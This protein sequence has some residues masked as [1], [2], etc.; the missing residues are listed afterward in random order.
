[1]KICVLTGKRGGFGAMRP[2][3]RLM[4]DS[5]YFEL[6]LQACDM[7]TDLRFGQTVDEIGDEFPVHALVIPSDDRPIQLG[8]IASGVASLLR[9]K[10]PDLLLLYGDRGESL[11]AAMVATEMCIPIAHLQGGDTT[12]TMDDRRR[13][14]ISQL[15]DLHFVSTEEASNNVISFNN[16]PSEGVHIVGDSHLDPIY[17]GDFETMEDVR[18]E[19][20]LNDHQP[21]YIVLLHP[22]PTDPRDDN[23]IFANM[24]DAIDDIEKQF[25][26]IY[27]CSDT[28]W[29]K[30][31]KQIRWYRGHPNIQ[32]HKNLPSRTFLGLMNIADM[33][34][35]N[36]SAGIIEAPYMDLA[37]LNIC[38]RQRGRLQSNN[39]INVGHTVSEIESGF[40]LAEHLGRHHTPFKKLYGNGATGKRIIH[41]LKEWYNEQA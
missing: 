13:H 11:A 9:E 30:I 1:M 2:M 27:P 25:V 19:L 38:N 15:A 34:I 10:Q 37:C 20:E 12:G 8:Y 16:A 33:I 14:A 39:V 40:G 36:S 24:M 35:G 41:K 22:D 4:R 18:S 29:E 6:T 7:H 3:L 28:G 32:I 5:S 23:L 31:V 26:I 21:V 17:D